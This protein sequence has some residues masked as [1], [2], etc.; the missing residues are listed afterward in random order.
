MPDDK[1]TEENLLSKVKSNP[2]EYYGKKVS[3]YTANGIS[4]WRIFYSDENNVFL[5]TT[6]YLPAEKAVA[7]NS[8]M[9]ANEVY[10]V[11]WDRTKNDELTVADTANVDKFSPVT[12]ETV[13]F[14]GNYATYLSG[15]CVSTLLDTNKWTVFVDSSKA[16]L[17][18]GSPTLNMLIASWN[19]KY[20]SD[21]LF[22]NNSDQIGYKVGTSSNPNNPYIDNSEMIIKEGYQL[23]E[24][25]NMYFPHKNTV[26]GSIGYWLASPSSNGT[27]RVVNVN[28]NGISND[29]PGNN[30]FGIRPVVCLR[31]TVNMIENEDGTIILK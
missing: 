22:C 4:D 12:S 31:D 28:Y 20:P 23:A 9:T 14:T 5:I 2:A 26:G 17:A 10:G 13:K 30:Y 25:N 29:D 21:K 19:A 3:G 27:E 24:E 7:C 1:P 16:S 11:Y 15:K 6:D 8:T 18:I